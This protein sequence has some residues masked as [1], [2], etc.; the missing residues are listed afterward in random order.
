[1]KLGMNIMLMNSPHLGT[2]CHKKNTNLAVVMTCVTGTILS[3]Y[4]EYNRNF[5][6]MIAQSV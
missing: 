2:V 5:R 3:F 6:A 1:M 4:M